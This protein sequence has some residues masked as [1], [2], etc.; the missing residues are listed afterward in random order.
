M[1]FRQYLHTEPV[2]A[3]YLFR[4][5][6]QS[7][8]VVVDPLEDQ[9]DFYV[10]EASR[11][12]LNIV[13]VIDTHL[14]ADHVSG[15][16]SLAEKT[17]AKYVLHSS[18]ETNYDYLSVKTETNYLLETRN[19]HSCIRRGIRQNISPSWFRINVEQMNLGLS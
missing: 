9:V 13:Y 14:H 2:A 15:A 8:G 4:C 12:G 11:L 17:G 19:L 18:A 10:S 1:L 3:S 16:R 6:S 7:Q 5:G